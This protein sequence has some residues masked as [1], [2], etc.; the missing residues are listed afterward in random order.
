[1]FVGCKDSSG[2]PD[3]YYIDNVNTLEE[4][5]EY[6][7][8]KMPVMGMKVDH[9]Y[10]RSAVLKS[11]CYK[12][13][14]YLNNYFEVYKSNLYF[15]EEDF[16][17]DLLKEKCRNCLNYDDRYFGCEARFKPDD[18]NMCANYKAPNIR[19]GKKWLK[20]WRS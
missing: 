2:Y 17:E 4:L 9:R 19:I 10:N 5:Q 16:L 8:N 15:V 3:Y 14:I 12:T 18:E 6:V 13:L 1:M 20:F 11:D 7:Q